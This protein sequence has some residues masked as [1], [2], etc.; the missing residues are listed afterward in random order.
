M[1]VYAYLN[2]STLLL[3]IATALLFSEVDSNAG[4]YR[5]TPR[6]GLLKLLRVITP[7]IG[8]IEGGYERVFLTLGLEEKIDRMRPR[9]EALG[10][11]CGQ[12]I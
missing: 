8:K 6:G 1:D 4:K 7:C 12:T 5:K 3:K 9:L 2:T 10:T 11:F